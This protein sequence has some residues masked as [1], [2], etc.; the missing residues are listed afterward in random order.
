MSFLE[1]KFNFYRQMNFSQGHPDLFASNEDDALDK[2]YGEPHS[3]YNMAAEPKANAWLNNKNEY[4]TVQIN[5]ME[6]KKSCSSI[7][8][9]ASTHNELS[10]REQD[11]DKSS[12]YADTNEEQ[13]NSNEPTTHEHELKLIK[14]SIADENNDLNKLVEDYIFSEIPDSTFTQQITTVSNKGKRMWKRDGAKNTLETE[15]LK[16]KDWSDVSFRTELGHLV[17]YTQ[18]QI[19]KWWAYR[20]TK[21]NMKVSTFSRKQK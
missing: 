9:N 17:G 3:F 20:L 14:D 7:N 12:V 11:V 10:T 5:D 8:E 2:Y 13:S 16:N 6:H 18:H 21:D 1:N 4:I 15:Y 19:Y